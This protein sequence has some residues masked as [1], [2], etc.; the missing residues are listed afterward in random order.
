MS[1][2]KI[3]VIEDDKRLND[4]LC[5][6]LEAEEYVATGCTDGADGLEYVLTNAYDLVIL[7]LMLPS[8]DGVSIIKEARK[9]EITTPV[10]MATALGMV[11]DRISG[12]DAGADDYIVKPFDM[13]E[14][15]ARIRALCRRPK[16]LKQEH[17]SFGDIILLPDELKLTGSRGESLLAKREMELLSVFIEHST[18]VLTKDF[19][20]N[21]IWGIDGEAADSILDIYLHFIRR[22]LK[23]VSENVVIST[24][25]KMGY[26]ME[27]IND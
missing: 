7:D 21:R 26:I 10:I 13:R 25:R 6:V 12:L 11:D 16:I 1:R 19:L 8:I 2:Y 5:E 17:L 4:L 9:R 22:H 3:L 18:K 23:M 20:Y 15:L 14:L 24:I 27:I